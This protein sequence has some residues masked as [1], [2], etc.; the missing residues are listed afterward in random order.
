M[1]VS[2]PT[3]LSSSMAMAADGQPIPVEQIVSGWPS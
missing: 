3:A 1:T 2:T